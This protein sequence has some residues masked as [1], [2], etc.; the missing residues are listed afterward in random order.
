MIPRPTFTL[1]FVTRPSTQPGE[2]RA[3]SEIDDLLLCNDGAEDGACQSEAGAESQD[4]GPG[5]DFQEASEEAEAPR[6]SKSLES[7]DKISLEPGFP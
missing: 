3:P 1:T 2:T 4:V 6:G 5:R 7:E